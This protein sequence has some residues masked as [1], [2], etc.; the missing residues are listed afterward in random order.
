ML[1]LHTIKPAKGSTKKIRRIGRGDASGRGTYSGRGQKG[2]KS[3][4]G[5]RKGLK[6]WG[7]KQ[8]L[9]KTPK[10]RGF[11]SLKEKNQVVNLADINRFFKDGAH[12]SPKSLLN[13]DLIDNI[14]TTVKILGTGELKIKNLEFAD[15]KLSKSAEEQIKKMDGK[16]K[17]EVR[18]KK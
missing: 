13:A 11:K 7:M 6:R 16:I 10:L 8:L 4:S 5:G 1:S 15:I 3:R 2:Q 14:K 9:L 18:N 12:V 17:A